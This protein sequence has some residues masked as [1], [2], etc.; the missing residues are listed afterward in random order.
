MYYFINKDNEIE[1]DGV[2][3]ICQN[4]NDISEVSEIVLKRILN[5]YIDNK[6]GDVCKPDLE[7]V[8]NQYPKIKIVTQ[9]SC[10]IN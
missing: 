9:S 7:R 8:H 10:N 1:D 6:F 3:A 4:I 5:Y 2:I